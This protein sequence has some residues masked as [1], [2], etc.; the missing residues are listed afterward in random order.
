MCGDLLQPHRA[1]L[2]RFSEQE[3]RNISTGFCNLSWC[4]YRTQP[5]IFV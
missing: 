2:L 3:D 5:P 4:Y 1:Y